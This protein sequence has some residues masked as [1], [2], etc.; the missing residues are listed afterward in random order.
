MKLQNMMLSQDNVDCGGNRGVSRP[1]RGTGTAGYPVPGRIHTLSKP[2]HSHTFECLVPTIIACGEGRKSLHILWATVAESG[3]Q[4][5]KLESLRRALSDLRP[6][7][8][9]S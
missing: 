9:A 3:S 4:S 1:N 7:V 6:A 8:L 2:A 5:M